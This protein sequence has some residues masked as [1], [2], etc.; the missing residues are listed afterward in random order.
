MKVLVGLNGTKDELDLTGADWYRL[1]NATL[2][3]D[4]L[5]PETGQ[6]KYGTIGVDDVDSVDDGG[7]GS[8]EDGMISESTATSTVGQS[9]GR[10]GKQSKTATKAPRR[11][12]FIPG[13]SWIKVSFPSAKDPSWVDRH[14][15][16][17]TCVVTI[18]ADDDF[19]KAFDF[20]PKIYSVLNKSGSSD[21][22][23]MSD[24]VLKDLVDTFPQLEG[25]CINR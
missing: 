21:M 15:S 1:P 16:V 22:E 10:R 8:S 19:V 2:P 5:D 11:S 7:E 24:K 17:S 25:E 13:S 9:G 12:K 3:R 14:G 18:E 6:V 4:E 23:R 20:K